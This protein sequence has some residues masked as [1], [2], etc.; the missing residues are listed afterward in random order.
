MPAQLAPRPAAPATPP[1]PTQLATQFALAARQVAAQAR[2]AATALRSGSTWALVMAAAWAVGIVGDAT[3][4]VLMMRTGLFEEANGAAAH[5][6][7]VFGLGGWV[8]LSGLMCVAFASLTLSRP[9]G[10]YAWTAAGV[11]VLICAVKIYTAG[12]N[13]ALWWTVTH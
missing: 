5:L 7:G 13:A 8:V 2:T 4:T 11:A 3:T 10:T 9:R 12:S 1:V 6:M